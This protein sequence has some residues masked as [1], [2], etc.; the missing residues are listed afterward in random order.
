MK[1]KKMTALECAGLA[2]ATAMDRHGKKALNDAL[3][4]LGRLCRAVMRQER[5]L[6]KKHRRKL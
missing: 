5:L 1:R 2:R 3:E 4:A 6:Q